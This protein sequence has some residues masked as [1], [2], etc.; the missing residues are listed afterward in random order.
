MGQNS[1]SHEAR[2]LYGV[3][4][5]LPL[6]INLTVS[7]LKIFNHL[8]LIF[9]IL[10]ISITIKYKDFKVRYYIHGP[11]FHMQQDK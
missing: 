1:S 2:I 6:E 10:F 8:T 9:F 11:L 7:L 3:H 5:I 4:F